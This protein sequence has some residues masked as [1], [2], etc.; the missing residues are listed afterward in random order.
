MIAG[1]TLPPDQSP[2]WG[3]TRLQGSS[4]PSDTKFRHVPSTLAA[5]PGGTRLAPVPQ[6]GATPNF[7]SLIYK[8]FF[9]PCFR[10]LLK[11]HPTDL[12]TDSGLCKLGKAART[13]LGAPSWRVQTG[14]LRVRPAA[15]EHGVAEMG[16]TQV[17]QSP[18]MSRARSV[19]STYGGR[20]CSPDL[21][22]CV[23]SAGVPNLFNTLSREGYT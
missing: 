1:S 7:E 4:H 23:S 12:N 18:A 6:G 19:G 3:A 11:T 13:H 8:C 10:L 14:S 2:T 17:I 22:E 21:E 20:S 16:I 15:A 9:Y 5:S